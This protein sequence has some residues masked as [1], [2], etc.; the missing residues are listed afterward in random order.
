M[1]RLWTRSRPSLSHVPN[2]SRLGLRYLSRSSVARNADTGSNGNSNASANNNGHGNANAS[3]R[4]RRPP[5]P[6]LD[7]GEQAIH[8][9][10]SAKFSPSKLQVQ[11]ISGG[12]GTFYAIGITSSAFA[13]LPIV[14]Q[15][16]LVNSVLKEE[17]SGIHG[18]QLK[19]MSE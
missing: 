5:P 16:R 3:A 19:T 4:Q 1:L 18:L 7:E 8:D 12:C 2:A 10:L 17:I 13:G 9:K 14:Q 15:H 6:P 11:D